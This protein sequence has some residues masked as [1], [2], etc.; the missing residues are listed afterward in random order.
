MDL[1]HLRCLVALAEDLHFGRAA[2]RLD[3]LPASLGRYIRQLEEDLGLALVNR[4][5]RSASLT[6]EG[7]DFL[8]E[9]RRLIAQADA[10][11]VRFRARARQQSPKVRIGA[12][13]SAAAGLLPL[14]LND[15]KTAQPL[16]QIQMVEDKTVRLLPRLLS[17]R[18]DLAFVRPPE[19]RDPRLR[20]RHLFFETAVVAIHAGHE[21]ANRPFLLIG[22]LA[23]LPM[24][25]PDRQSRPHSHDLTIKV[26]AEAG[27]TAR[28]GQVANEKQTIV[29]L[30]AA[31]IGLAIVPRWTARL[32]VPGVV[33][34]PLVAA[35]GQGMNRLP[36]AVVY[37]ADTRDPA[38]DAA[39]DIL[40]RHLDVYAAEA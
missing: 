3:M 40:F 15:L 26:F 12:I 28:V 18:L 11:A 31:G 10:L 1:L 8:E 30:V 22:D 29:N 21:L 24:I 39:L 16:M 5:T 20:F 38:R 14:L 35:E 27:L 23:D 33:F 19:R 32:A 34:V 37:P 13:D 36:L 2:Q 25:V 9:A 7:A 6:A 4:T 17:G